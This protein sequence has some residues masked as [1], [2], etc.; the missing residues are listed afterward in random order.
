MVYN[1]YQMLFMTMNSGLFCPVLELE[2]CINNGLAISGNPNI[3][4]LLNRK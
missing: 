1:S 4:Y 3:V 2:L